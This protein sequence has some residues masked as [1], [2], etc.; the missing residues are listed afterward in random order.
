TERTQ[1]ARQKKTYLRHVHAD[2]PV[3]TASQSSRGYV[4]F[5]TDFQTSPLL[6]DCTS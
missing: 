6:A 1:T 3:R 4:E 5:T 2:P